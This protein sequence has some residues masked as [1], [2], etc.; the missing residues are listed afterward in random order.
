ML[1]EGGTRRVALG[2][3]WGAGPGAEAEPERRPRA[4]VLVFLRHFG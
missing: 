4:V 3:F 1:P 2:A